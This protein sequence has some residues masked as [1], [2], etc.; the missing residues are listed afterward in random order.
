MPATA[1]A[2][3]G[4]S[5]GAGGIVKLIVGAGQ[6][7]QGKNILKGLT[8]PTEEVPQEEI[9]NQKLLKQQSATGLPTE[10]YANAMKNIQRQ[11]LMALRGAHDRRGGLGLISNIQQ[12]T[13]DATLGLDAKDAAMKVANTNA[14]VA[15]NNRLASWK[16]KVWQQN[17]LGK[18]N[19]QYNYGMGLLGQGNQNLVGGID[20]TLAG[21]GTAAYGAGLF[22]SAP[23]VRYDQN[24]GP[25]NWTG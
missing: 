18:Y 24:M 25:Q 16:D 7:R 9:E 4:I 12:G 14:Y 15:G 10:Q 22:G 5:Q 23:G 21:A 13:N 11:Q 17:V 1:A 2:A 8:Y 20:Q 6:K 19:Q 3:Q